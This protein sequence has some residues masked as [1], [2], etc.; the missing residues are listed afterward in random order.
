[1]AR[2]PAQ[3]VRAVRSLEMPF[4][5]LQSFI[6]ALEAEGEL[7]RV[8]VPVS[9]ELEITEIATRMVKFGG[10]AMLFENVDGAKFPLAINLL[11]S[12]RRIELA[13]GMHP[14]QIGEELATFAERVNPPTLGALWA[15]RG[16]A[17]RLLRSRP[18]RVRRGPAREVVNDEPD[19]S[20]LPVLKCWPGDG[21]RFI[22]FPL[23]ISRD[24]DTAAPNM[25]IYRMH[26][27]DPVTTGM[28]MQIQKGG[29]FHHHRAESRNE[30]LEMAVALGGDPALMLA[31]V[32]PLPEGID[33]LAFS[34]IIRGGR[35][36]TMRGRTVGLNV[37]AN[38]EFVLEGR[39]APGRRMTEG[40]FGDHFG[41]YSE[42]AEF[43]VFQL[44]T[45]THRKDAVYPAT[46]V[47]KPPQE[48][49]YLG[50]AAQVALKPII[51]LLRREIVDLW[52]YYEAGFHN[53]LVVSVQER[54]TRE[55][56][57]TAL[58]LLG[59]GQLSLTK[60]L[61]LVSGDVNPRDPSAV[62]Q[63]IR[64]NF[65]AESDF[66]LIART[67]IDTLD[68]TGDEMHKG[69]KM[70]ID[71]TGPPT[72]AGGATAVAVP[73]KLEQLTPGISRSRLVGKALLVIQ[74]S[75]NGRQVLQNLVS[76]P[77]IGAVK[78]I[79]VVSKDVNI[80]DDVELLWGI[81]TRFDP[82]RDILFSKSELRG[83]EPVHSG[84]MGIDA[85]WKAGYPKPLVMDPEIIERVDT[86][87]AD[88][89]K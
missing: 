80:D 16:T 7:N 66:H 36:R 37:P 39:V 23:V 28:H 62:L 35:T 50:D 48:D 88:Y 75:G 60:A 30:P 55:P 82:A 68:F 84:V 41:H 83:I 64:R 72:S 44:T 59:E 49:R 73:A 29:G 53:L 17:F 25:G 8:T 79:A 70:I 57:K 85:T 19:L 9:P 67:A 69:S 3:R 81:F 18:K 87:W 52:A 65:D 45:M 46:V 42:A 24:P 40:P 61:V 33:E 6:R 12:E 4:S 34:G 74:T 10:S 47:G 26:V 22:T 51:R 21:G 1:M 63:A 14:E 58:G 86:R 56:L 2:S 76:N 43:P 77:L 20:T 5:D 78:I 71:A 32:M 31:A 13:L 11:A 15:N 38:A 54:Y 27:Y 89:W